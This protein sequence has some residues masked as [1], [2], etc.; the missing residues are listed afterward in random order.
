MQGCVISCGTVVFFK[1]SRKL[2]RSYCSLITISTVPCLLYLWS[3]SLSRFSR[4]LLG[5]MKHNKF[6][7]NSHLFFSFSLL[8]HSETN[9]KTVLTASIC[10]KI[11]WLHKLYHTGT[12]VKSLAYNTIVLKND[13]PGTVQWA[14]WFQKSPF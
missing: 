10:R 6:L 14:I 5:K 3:I 8:H 11:V 1:K 4:F 12:A 9:F 13:H 2:S 7:R